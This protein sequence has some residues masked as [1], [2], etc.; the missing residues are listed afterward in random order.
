[1]RLEDSEFYLF[2]A[3]ESDRCLCTFAPDATV[4][5][6]QI[7]CPINPGHGR[8]GRFLSDFDLVV[9]CSPPADVLFDWGTHRFVQEKALDIIRSEGLTGFW[10]KPAKARMKRTGESVPIRQLCVSGWGGVVAPESG[11][12][13]D[14]YC[15]GCQFSHYSPMTDP[16]SLIDPLAW[17][18]SDFFIIW[19]LPG[20]PLSPSACGR[21]SG[22]TT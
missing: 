5:K 12:R 15:P 2:R 22:I 20:F 10:T 7:T 8:N 1:M 19:P 11:I 4:R 17:D 13:M 16:A 21:F 9:P 18:G 6:E 14:E 3:P